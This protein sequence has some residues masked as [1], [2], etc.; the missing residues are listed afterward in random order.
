MAQAPDV[1]AAVA[2]SF[3]DCCVVPLPSDVVVK[4]DLA[5][6]GPADL[7]VYRQLKVL[8][9]GSLLHLGHLLFLLAVNSSNFRDLLLAE[10][11]RVLGL[12]PLVDADKTEGML[13]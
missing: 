10:W 2:T 4:L 13:A 1:H 6:S 8:S 12:D 3:T 5:D 7:A 11:T 9:L